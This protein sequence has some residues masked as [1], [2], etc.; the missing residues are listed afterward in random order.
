MEVGGRLLDRYSSVVNGCVVAILPGTGSNCQMG[1]VSFM[2]VAL[3]VPLINYDVVFF[4]FCK[5]SRTQQHPV[6]YDKI[7]D[8]IAC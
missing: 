7:F 5:Q 1:V 3:C 6:L 2:L 4:F 8:V